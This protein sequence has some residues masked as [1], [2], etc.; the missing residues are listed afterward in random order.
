NLQTSMKRKASA[1]CFPLEIAHPMLSSLLSIVE[2]WLPGPRSP[3]VISASDRRT[4]RLTRPTLEQLEDRCLLSA[5]TTVPSSTDALNPLTVPLDI[6]VAAQPKG[7][8]N[9][10]FLGDSIAEGYAY[11]T[12]MPIWSA[13]MAP[14]GAVDYGMGNQTTQTLLYQ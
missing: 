3:R 5:A 12:G 7:N 14:L 9:V 11:G 2:K 1:K 6:F 10:V 13:T 4:P 8:P